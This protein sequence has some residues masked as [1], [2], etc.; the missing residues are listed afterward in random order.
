MITT[1]KKH[2]PARDHATCSSDV[3]VSTPL[4]ANLHSRLNYLVSHNQPS[5]HLLYNLL[6]PI[7]I[8]TR[9][10]AMW[11]LDGSGHEIINDFFSLLDEASK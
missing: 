3:D 8:S 9:S 11:L 4:G 6:Q 10:H 5:L 2:V 7:N 1:R